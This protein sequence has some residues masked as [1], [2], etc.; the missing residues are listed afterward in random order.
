VSEA[1]RHGKALGAWAGGE[2]VLDTSAVPADAPGVV[3]TTSGP[4]ALEQLTR[5]LGEHRVWDRFAAA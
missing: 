2:T 3:V 5:L 1:F 4:A